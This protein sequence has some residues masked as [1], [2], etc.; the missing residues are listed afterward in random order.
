MLQTISSVN[1]CS[2]SATD[3]TIG[4]VCD[5]LFDDTTWTIS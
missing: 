4:T 3:G 5:M 2:I 1:G